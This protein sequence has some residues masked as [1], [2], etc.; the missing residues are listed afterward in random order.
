VATPTNVFII[1]SLGRSD[2]DSL[3]WSAQKNEQRRGMMSTMQQQRLQE[4]IEA[5]RAAA[6][7]VDRRDEV[8]RPASDTTAIPLS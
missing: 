7:I 8:L 1:E 5:L 4:W 2:A 6:K 3:A